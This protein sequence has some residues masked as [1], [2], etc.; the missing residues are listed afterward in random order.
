MTQTVQTASEA[1]DRYSAKV[2]VRGPAECWPWK[3]QV[4]KGGYGG[5]RFGRYQLAH[6]AALVFAGREI[7]T[8]MVVDHTC[9]NRLCVNPSHLRV[10]TV[11]QNSVENSVAIAAINAAKTHCIHGHAL[12]NGNLIR[13]KTGGRDCRKCLNARQKKLT[14]K[15]LADGM[16]ECLARVPAPELS[17]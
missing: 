14:V 10:V 16:V 4:R 11:R 8:G 7:P 15:R 6:H 13:R 1:F 12:T 5:F 2:D 9:R 3:A 17:P